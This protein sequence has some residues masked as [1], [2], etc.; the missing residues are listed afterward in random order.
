L[1]KFLESLQAY[2]TPGKLKHFKHS[3]EQVTA[4]KAG[5]EFLKDVGQLAEM[6]RDAM[7]LGSYLSSAESLLP[8]ADDWVRKV[9]EERA[10]VLTGLKDPAKR[11][12]SAF[13]REVAQKLSALKKEYVDAYLSLHGKARLGKNDDQKK[14]ELAKDPRI[15]RLNK[16]ANVE[17]LSR[18]DLEKFRED[19]GSLKTCFLLTGKDLESSPVCP[20]CNFRPREEAVSVPAKARLSQLE[21]QLDAIEHQ[22]TQALLSNL[23]DPTVKDLGALKAKQKKLVLDFVKKGALPDDVNGEFVKA[24]Q[25][26]FAGLEKVVVTLENLKAAL[27][28]GGTPCTPE[29]LRKRLDGY[30]ES[31]TRGKDATKVRIVLE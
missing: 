7:P 18:S 29:E 9:K 30:I 23:E 21:N 8:E 22:W 17:M 13:R 4:H 11:G 25:D 12:D 19:V 10:R 2:N 3:K 14:G 6:A 5:L 26:A 15:K 24:L 20:H 27:T 31:L 16:L 1:K 28:E